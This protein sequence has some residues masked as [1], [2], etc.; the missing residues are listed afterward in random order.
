ML[1]RSRFVVLAVVLVVPV[2]ALIATGSASGKGF[3][4]A[5]RFAP[6][7]TVT[8]DPM[9]H[10]A[11]PF[12]GHRLPSSLA[13]SITGSS[14]CVDSGANVRVNQECT[15]QSQSSLLGRSQSQNETGAAVNPT[16]PLDIL[17][18]QNDYRRGDAN[19]GADFSLDGGRHWG[20]GLA[21]M[22][23]T[24]PGFT[25]PRHYWTSG[26][27]TSV[28]FDSSGEAYLMCQVFDR[29]SSTADNSTPFGASGFLLFRSADNGASWSFP[30]SAVALANGT[31]SDGIGLLDKEYMA[32]D[33]NAASLFKDRI[34]VAWVQYSTDFSS[35]PVHFAY[36]TDHGVSW[37]Q[38][39]VISGSSATLCPINFSGAPAGTCDADQFVNP[40]VAPNGDLYVVFQ[41]FNNCSGSLGSLGFPCSGDPN[42]NHNQM[43]I[44]KSTNG[45]VSFGPPVKVTDFYD[46]PDCFTY[47]GQDFGRGCI[48]TAPLS[49]TSIFRAEDYPTG[50]ALS[51]TNIVVDFGSYL[52]VHSN[53]VLGNCSPA[54]ISSSTFVNTFSGVGVVNGCNNDI[55]QSVSTNGGA[56][57]SG[58][59]V[60][61]WSLPSVNDESTT[62]PLADQW[63]Q[64]SARNPAGQ[65]VVSYYDRKYGSDQSSGFMDITLATGGTHVRV[66]SAS[67]PP[68]NEFPASNGYSLFLGDYSALAVGAD[69]AAHPVWSDTRNPI[70]TYNPSG[71]ARHL[72]F[73]GFGADIY[74]ARIG[75]G[76]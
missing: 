33:T 57:F 5:N 19:C 12:N 28:A 6:S 39:G 34:Y 20:S 7:G 67:M 58:A 46:L 13:L 75:G 61:P 74:T 51:N 73:A 52:N 60:P 2:V 32:I 15:N 76:H 16:N 63:W 24:V 29:D 66:T 43:L 50:V 17:A 8:V 69:G 1:R 65:D 25:A 68:S 10:P 41:N 49:G 45:G 23:F 59:T 53:P 71:D 22:G 44:V 4:L 18:S 64:W 38:T 30:G 36:S 11:L 42:D 47:T 54:G 26:G 35:S 14:G 48:P 3:T 72:I 27:D 37:H 56:S 9:N 21:P 40:F 70:L 62:G 31:G 55:V